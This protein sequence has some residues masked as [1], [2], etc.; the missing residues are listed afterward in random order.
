M[1]VSSFIIYPCTFKETLEV[2]SGYDKCFAFGLVVMLLR[3]LYFHQCELCI[4]WPTLPESVGLV[5]GVA[6]DE[7]VVYGLCVESGRTCP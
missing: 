7:E 4:T 2:L 5:H 6:G 3:N 1:Q